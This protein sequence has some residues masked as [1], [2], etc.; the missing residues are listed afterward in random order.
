MVKICKSQEILNQ[1]LYSSDKM[2]PGAKLLFSMKNNKESCFK[3]ILIGYPV[4]F[5][6]DRDFLKQK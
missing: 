6:I 3:I 5:G 1:Q 2:N 4:H